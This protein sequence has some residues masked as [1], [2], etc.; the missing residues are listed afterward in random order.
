MRASL[1]DVG[2]YS[3]LELL[4][5]YAGEADDLRPW[6]ANAQINRDSNLRLQYL[7]GMGLNLDE[8]RV[9]F[10]TMLRHYRFPAELLHGSEIRKKAL[11]FMLQQRNQSATIRALD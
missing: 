5:T 1:A 11:Q 3:A 2:I 7:A 8:G 10:A 9:I 6:L 4:A